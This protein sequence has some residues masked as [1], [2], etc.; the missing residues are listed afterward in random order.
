MKSF[1]AACLTLALVGCEAIPELPV[2]AD[3]G[4]AW[5]QHHAS[6]T[7]LQQWRIDGRLA[8]NNGE[9]AWNLNLQWQQQGDN[10][11]IDLSGPFGSGHV[12]LQGGQQG[13]VLRDNDQQTF[14]AANAEELLYDKTGVYMPV[15]ALRYWVIGI[16]EPQRAQLPAF[17]AQGRLAR[18]Q[19]ANWHVTYRRYAQANG[20]ALPDKIFLVRDDKQYDV[21]LVVDQWTLN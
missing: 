1:A 4:A 10:Y 18:L 15:T 19:Q 16:P 20:L 12:Q 13:V 7:G 3:G 14:T 6:I 2:F 5:Q 17:D 9:Q 21:R 11:L 8:I